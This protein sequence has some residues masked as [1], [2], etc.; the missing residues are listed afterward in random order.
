MGI[1]HDRLVAHVHSSQWFMPSKDGSVPYRPWFATGSK[2]PNATQLRKYCNG[3]L[4]HIIAHPGVT[5][6]CHSYSR[7]PMLCLIA[8]L[9]YFIYVVNFFVVYL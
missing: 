5:L 8:E 4:A 9:H 7:F 6:V 1:S 2:D 3:V